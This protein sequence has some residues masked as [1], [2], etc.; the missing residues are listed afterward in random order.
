MVQADGW[1]PL[2]V[3]S[4][5]GRG[6]AVR[7]LLGAGAA[8]NQADVSGDGGARFLCVCVSVFV[9][10]CWRSGT[11]VGGEGCAVGFRT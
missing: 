6:E 9:C 1:T 2:L 7:A 3:A 5:R 11:G 8:V 10:E 4:W